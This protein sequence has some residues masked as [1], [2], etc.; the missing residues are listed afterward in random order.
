M[1]RLYSLSAAIDLSGPVTGKIV[2][3]MSEPVTLAI[4]SGLLCETVKA[5]GEDCYDA[6]AEVTNMIAGGA[7][8]EIASHEPICLSIPKVMP[9]RCI[10]CPEQ[11]PTL[12]IPFDTA[13]GRLVLQVSMIVLKRPDPAPDPQPHPEAPTQA[14]PSSSKAAGNDNP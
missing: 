14:E 10:T 11:M 9:T 4:A 2:L 3:S 1:H 12:V 5:I 13:M 7:K 6:I 8:K